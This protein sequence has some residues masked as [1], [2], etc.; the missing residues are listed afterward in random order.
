MTIDRCRMIGDIAQVKLQSLRKEAE[1]AKNWVAYCQLLGIL[2]F[3]FVF[4]TPFFVKDFNYEKLDNETEHSMLRL[5]SI[6]LT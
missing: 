1:K 2:L 5:S 4:H 6:P 3:S